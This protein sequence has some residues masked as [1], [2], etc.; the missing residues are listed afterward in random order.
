M[1]ATTE[2]MSPRQAEQETANES[3]AGEEDPLAGVDQEGPGTSSQ[4]QRG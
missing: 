4:R 2:S 3:V 1:D